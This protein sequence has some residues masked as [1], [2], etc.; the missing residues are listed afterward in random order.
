MLEAVVHDPMRGS[1]SAAAVQGGL[2]LSSRLLRPATST[3]PSD[4]SVAVW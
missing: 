3:V 2:G 4:N 1:Y